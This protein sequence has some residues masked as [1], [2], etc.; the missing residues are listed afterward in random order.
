M[1]TMKKPE[2]M[3][4]RLPNTLQGL[5]AGCQLC[6]SVVAVLGWRHTPG[7]LELFSLR[8]PAQLFT[9]SNGVC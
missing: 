6:L 3:I 9:A 4:V 8:G 1:E 5:P 7:L 2:C